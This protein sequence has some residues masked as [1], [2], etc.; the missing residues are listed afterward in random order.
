MNAVPLDASQSAATFSMS[1]PM[2]SL[3]H[4]A[5]EAKTTYDLGKQWKQG[6]KLQPETFDPVIAEVRSMIKTELSTDVQTIQTTL[7]DNAQAVDDCAS[8]LGYTASP[9][10]YDT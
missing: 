10:D 6:A 2:Q 3:I 9:G 8:T 5:S 4:M 1:T 7:D